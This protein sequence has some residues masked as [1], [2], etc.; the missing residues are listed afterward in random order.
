MSRALI[1][2]AILRP[3]LPARQ[4]GRAFAIPYLASLDVLHLGERT[5]FYSMTFAWLSETAHQEVAREVTPLPW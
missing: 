2:L 1:Q 4:V 3:S 5:A